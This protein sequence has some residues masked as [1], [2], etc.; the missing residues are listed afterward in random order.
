MLKKKQQQN[1]DYKIKQHLNIFFLVV[2]TSSQHNVTDILIRL[3]VD[4]TALSPPYWTGYPHEIISW[5]I[6]LDVPLLSIKHRHI[7]SPFYRLNSLRALHLLYILPANLG[8]T[9][10]QFASSRYS[11]YHHHS[12]SSWVGS[13][14]CLSLV[15]SKELFSRRL[16]LCW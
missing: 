15:A 7:L 2:C 1:N 16:L 5:L 8:A 10:D 4:I 12:F 14:G 11:E 13:V 9:W 3:Y 6:I